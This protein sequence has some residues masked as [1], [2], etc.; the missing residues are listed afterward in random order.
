MKA[1]IFSIIILSILII[2]FIEPVTRFY[3]IPLE[4]IN[5]FYSSL[6]LSAL[7]GLAAFCLPY[8]RIKQKYALL[9]FIE[10]SRTVVYGILLLSF[11]FVFDFG[12]LSRN[13]AHI[14]STLPMLTL[15]IMWLYKYR[16]VKTNQKEIMKIFS[17]VIYWIPSSVLI[18]SLPFIDRLVLVSKFSLH[19]VA[20]F[21][22]AFSMV[23]INKILT[24]VVKKNF[25]LITFGIQPTEQNKIRKIIYLDRIFKKFIIHLTVIT[26]FAI[27]LAYT[28]LLPVQYANDLQL[29]LLLLI[30]NFIFYFNSIMSST[31]LADYKTDFIFK[32]N[33]FGIAIKYL[34]FIALIEH[35]GLISLAFGYFAEAILH[36]MFYG[37][38]FRLLSTASQHDSLKQIFVIS[39]ASVLMLLIGVNYNLLSSYWTDLL[40]FIFI[41]ISVYSVTQL[42]KAFR[43]ILK[44]S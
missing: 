27:F 41:T 19:S 26:F 28:Y 33:I 9:L 43:Q 8:F 25:E 32:V 11:I 17:F 23:S 29:C 35:L 40:I 36:Y 31:L 5:V 13:L 39:T 44:I 18:V 20:A 38:Q 7:E 6:L 24:E 34:T 21:S 12:L 3:K 42:V 2:I 22:L 15:P 37:R 16:T 4:Y 10:V 14:I 30:G 1:Y